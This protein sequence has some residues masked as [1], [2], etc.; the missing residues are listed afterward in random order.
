MTP[1]SST[2]VL[3]VD[4]QPIVTGLL[5][6]MLGAMGLTDVASAADGFEGLAMLRERRF[7]LVIADI[8][9]TPMTGLQMLRAMRADPAL[10]DL[11]V[12]IM[13]ARRDEAP[14]EEARR[15]RVNGYLT[16]PFTAETLREAISRILAVWGAQDQPG[17]E[18]TG[19]EQPGKARP[20]QAA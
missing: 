10:K 6:R 17:R 4:D 16:K 3:V 7:A 12:L 15:A 1:E 13:T 8:G 19:R 14:H 18:Q 11:P 9:M 2:A 5:K 20:G